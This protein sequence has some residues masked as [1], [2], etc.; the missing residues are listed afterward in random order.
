MFLTKKLKKIEN[1]NFL[2]AIGSE[3]MIRYSKSKQI[4][5]ISKNLV[6]LTIKKI[7]F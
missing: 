6:N 7:I 1:H 4:F 2:N 3:L 5:Q